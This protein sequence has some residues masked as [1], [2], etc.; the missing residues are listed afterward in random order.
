[1]FG[2]AG[3]KQ[4]TGT[5]RPLPPALVAPE[6]VF[7]QVMP[8][9]PTIAPARS[10]RAWMDATPERYAYRCLPL[11]IANATGWEILCPCSFEAVYYGGDALD[12]IQLRSTDGTRRYERLAGS[13]FGSGV[14]TFQVGYLLRTSPGW[15][16]WARGIPNSSR[17]KIVPLEGLIETDWTASTFT[18][19]WRFTRPGTVRF[20]EGEAFCFITLVPHAS[21]DRVEPRLQR[22]DENPALEQAHSA[23]AEDRSKFNDRLNER[24]PTAVAAGWQRTYFKGETGERGTPPPFHLTKRRLRPPRWA[25]GHPK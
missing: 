13:H 16:I 10:E 6:L 15:A 23:W 20:Q 1:V 3:R 12:A 19:N 11:S 9:A 25:G 24:D 14:L 21:L 17:G 2:R 22:I 18:M 8:D 5:E 7:Y 4:K